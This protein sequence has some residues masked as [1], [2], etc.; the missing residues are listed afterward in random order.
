MPRKEI[1]YSKTVMYKIVSKDLD[2]KFV[3]IGSTTDI[4]KRK[5]S[6][7]SIC[8]N[9]KSNRHNLKVYQT[10]RENGGFDN[11]VMIKIENYPCNDKNESLARERYWYEFYHANLNS[12]VP[13]RSKS[14]Y[15]KKYYKTN[16]E[17]KIEYNKIY[18]KINKLKI[19]E[20]AEKYREINKDK[21]KEYNQQN[22]KK[23]HESHICSCGGKYSI[24]HKIRHFKS[25][26][27]KTW[28]QKQN[29]DS[30]SSSSDSESS[31]SDSESSSDSDS[32]SDDE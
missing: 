6:H 16:K 15:D 3:Y 10:I 14:E 31:S 18:N 8:I 2:N 17:K 12:Y 28:L 23:I 29:N 22:K 24:N 27:H 1:D 9:K 30:E 7:K 26:K 32:S 11:F 5:S 4:T 21:I 13:N 25:L 19:K 20:K